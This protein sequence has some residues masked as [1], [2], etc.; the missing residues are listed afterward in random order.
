VAKA[1]IA[2]K[3]YLT[4]D[5]DEALR[6][7]ARSREWSRQHVIQHAIRRFLEVQVGIR[8]AK[9]RQKG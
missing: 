5:E 3:L 7:I 2:V 9:A 8:A 4:E 6:V 1:K